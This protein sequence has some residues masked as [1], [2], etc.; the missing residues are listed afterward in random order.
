MQVL[1]NLDL[2]F[3]VT[4]IPFQTLDPLHLHEAPNRRNN[5]HPLLSQVCL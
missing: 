2:Q 5:F 3:I 1:K 4:A